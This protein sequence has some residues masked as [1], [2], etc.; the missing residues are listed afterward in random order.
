M[1]L[2]RHA[3]RHCLSVRNGI[4]AAA[5]LIAAGSFSQQTLA[6]DAS[7]RL[8]ARGLLQLKAGQFIAATKYFNGAVQLDSKD[9]RALFYLGVALNRIGQHGAALESFQRMWALKVTNR[10]L[11]LEGGWAAIAQGRTALAITMLEPYVKANPKNAKAREF[12]GRAYIGDGR[13]DDAERELK[14]AIELDTAVKPTALYYLANIAAL[15]KDTKGVAAALTSILKENPDSRT[16]NILRDTL[17][18]AATAPQPERK[19]WFAALSVS[20]GENSNVV[21]LPDNA[22]LPTDVSS[23]ASKLLRT[24]LDVGYSWRLDDISSLTAGYGFTHERY[25][26]VEGFDSMSNTVYL[27]Y[28]R[29]VT[30]RIEG[31]VRISRGLSATDGETKVRR[32]TISPSASYRWDK[33]DVT[34]LRYNLSYTNYVPEPIRPALDRDVRNHVFTLSHRTLVDGPILPLGVNLEVGLS[35]TLNNAEGADYVYD[36]LGGYISA[37]RMFPLEIRG[38]ITFSHQR[39]TYTELNSLAGAG[40]A[41]NREDRIDRLNLFLERPLTVF[42]VKNATVFLNWQYLNNKSNLSFFNYEQT[43]FNF[44]ITARF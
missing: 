10:Q 28:R 14:R 25:S 27:D 39:D 15:R 2:G 33:T 30:E 8:V 5:L 4:F 38:A 24:Q 26:D 32:T 37:S 16:G 23:R 20:G 12:L 21:G 34:S 9:P 1:P 29:K 3:G 41:F 31:G 40:F 36:G 19:P 6:S 22:V 42:N 44:G 35:R 7:D 11:G 17:R 18:R 43:S 13:L